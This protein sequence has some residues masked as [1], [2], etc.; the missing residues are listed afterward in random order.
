MHG[1]DW[2][3]W[4]DEILHRQRVHPKVTWVDGIATGV[5]NEAERVAGL[6]GEVK[7]TGHT[8][9]AGV[10]GNERGICSREL[11]HPLNGAGATTHGGAIETDRP[12]GSS[13]G[14]KLQPVRD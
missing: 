3:H 8:Y 6:H 11:P 7:M 14:L 13:T 12:I 1:Q 4:G 5:K 9:R 10:Q 2:R